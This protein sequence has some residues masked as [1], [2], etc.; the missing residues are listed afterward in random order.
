MNGLFLFEVTFLFAFACSLEVCWHLVLGRIF[1]G[2][3][4][5]FAAK[6]IISLYIFVCCGTSCLELWF[7]VVARINAGSNRMDSPRIEPRLCRGNTRRVVEI[8]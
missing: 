6:F 4:L 2:T 5:A 3:R 1:H 7:Q 8:H